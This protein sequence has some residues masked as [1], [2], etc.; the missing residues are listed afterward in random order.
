MPDPK[1]EYLYVLVHPLYPNL[2]KIGKTV[3]PKDRLRVFNTS[4]PYRR[5]TYAHVEEVYDSGLGEQ[6][7][8]RMLASYRLGKT[9]WFQI[10]P[11]DAIRTLRSLHA[12]TLVA[13]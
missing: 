4:D 3:R 11:D 1:G 9:E 8:H 6:A 5:Y 10:H 12:S 2:C 7:L 13:E